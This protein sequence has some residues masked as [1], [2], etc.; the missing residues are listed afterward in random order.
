V[1]SGVDLDLTPG[2]RVAVVGV[3]GAGK[4]TLAAVLL[5]FLEYGAGDVTLDGVELAELHGDRVRRVVGFVS[6]DVHVFDTTLEENLRLARR[7]ATRKDLH[8]ALARARLLDWVES[9]PLGLQTEVGERGV[10]ISGGQRQ[11]LAIARALLANFPILILDEPGEHLD[12]PT[13]D[14]ILADLLAAERSGA[15]LLITHRL[16]GL[17][18]VDEIVVLDGGAVVE[19]GS[20]TNLLARGGRYATSWLREAPPSPS[21][22]FWDGDS[23]NG[24]ST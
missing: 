2:R 6:Q 13:T 17:E 23:G 22:E 24:V 18:A 12:T 8:D 16:A 19:R 20:H 10:R 3:S 7:E 14:A 4:S 21:P 1:L 11:R 5:R 9:L 15:I